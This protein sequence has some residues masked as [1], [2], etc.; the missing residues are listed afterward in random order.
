MNA[1]LQ[2]TALLMPMSQDG[3][4]TMSSRE[5]AELVDSRHDKVK[6]SIERLAS[7]KV[8]TLPPIG[9]VS[10]DGPGPKALAEYRVSKCD[11]YFAQLSP[12]FTARLVDRWQALE[13]QEQFQRTPSAAKLTGELAVMECFARLLRPAPSSQLTMLG[14][15]AKQNGLDPSFLPAYALDAPTDAENG[16]SL[17]TSSLTELLR[18]HGIKIGAAK[19]NAMLR[20]AGM[21]VERTRK[22]TSKGS[23]NGEE[24]FWCISERGVAFVTSPESPREMQLHWYVDRFPELR[25]IVSAR[26]LG[27]AML[28]K[29][30]IGFI[31]ASCNPRAPSYTAIV[32]KTNG[33][34]IGVPN[35]AASKP[36]QRVRLFCSRLVMPSM[37]AGREEP[38]GSPVPHR[39][40]N[41][42]FSHHPQLALGE[43]VHAPQMR[44]NMTHPSA[45]PEQTQSAFL[46]SPKCA[47]VVAKR[48]DHA[49]L[50]W[51]GDGVGLDASRAARISLLD[52][53]GLVVSLTLAEA[54][55]RADEID[56]RGLYRIL[57]AARCAFEA[58]DLS[59]ADTQ[60]WRQ[61]GAGQMGSP[62]MIA[63]H[64]RRSA[65][66]GFI[67]SRVHSRRRA[68]LRRAAAAFWHFLGA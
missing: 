5:L 9:E 59:E 68:A 53:G 48:A 32:P 27:N 52:Q 46:F 66:G 49:Q 11:S 2:P 37:V 12:E 24:R 31:G 42:R 43:A 39:Y 3:A 6:Q 54:L 25:R 44:H 62:A 21:L 10:N 28:L 19:Y 60:A 29:R 35:E 17:P 30:H 64:I 15:I 41:F 13:A 56:A 65:M 23:R 58:G 38:K 16:S 47:R 67:A 61:W 57:A 7:R 1:A 63:P 14:T 22:S 50:R 51:I 55:A 20:D 4:A 34:G 36:Q 18:T 40:A 33:T 26:L 45:L 8:I